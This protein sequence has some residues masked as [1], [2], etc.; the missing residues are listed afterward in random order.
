[1]EERPCACY[2]SVS[3]PI[4]DVQ[5]V[6]TMKLNSLTALA[7]AGSISSAPAFGFERVTFT[8]SGETLVGHLYL[9]ANLAAGARVP[10]VVLLGPMT[11]V[12]EQ[13]PTEY[14][15]RL[16]AH[17]FAA[18]VFDPRYHGESGGQPRRWEN[19][20]A[21]AQDVTAALDYLVALPLVDANRVVGLGI[22]QGSSIVIRTA[23]DDQRIKALV[24]VAGQY[25]DYD[26]DLL[27][28]GAQGRRE[29]FARGMVAQA[30]YLTS[31]EVE[32][33]PAVDQTRMDVGMP[34]ELVWS[35]YAPWAAK[36]N[37]ENRYAVMSDADLLAYESL[38]AATRLDKPYLMIHS[39]NC[40]LPSAARRHFAS[41]PSVSK[42]L[43]WEGQTGHLQY[44]DDPVVL[45]A[46]ADR[47]AAFFAVSL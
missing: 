17:G 23:A 28:L 35:W 25:R 46:T 36:S 9:P 6:S 29:R 10:A 41:V 45:D 16:A 5:P 42:S 22:C 15:R 8:S 11:F 43:L 47:I 37:W 44:Y 33:V 19:P 14:A 39:D 38:S 24:T 21:K 13:V 20:L 27:W 3:P 32:Y 2:A 34:G 7:L 1:M 18:L 31:G 12:K 26:S 4:Y 30:K 40:F